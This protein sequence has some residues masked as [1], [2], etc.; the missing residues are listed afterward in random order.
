MHFHDDTTQDL[1]QL[2]TCDQ[3]IAISSHHTCLELSS[4]GKLNYV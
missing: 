2:D 4:V 3:K 1:N